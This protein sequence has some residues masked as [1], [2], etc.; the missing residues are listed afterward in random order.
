MIESTFT[1]KNSLKL[2]ALQNN[3]TQVTLLPL[4]K[5]VTAVSSA[6]LLG[7]GLYFRSSL[8]PAALTFIARLGLNYFS[9]PMPWEP[10][11]IG[12]SG[13]PL[14][15]DLERCFPEKKEQIVALASGGMSEEERAKCMI[16]V[17]IKGSI[18][19]FSDFIK[20]LR[21]E[22]NLNRYYQTIRAYLV[23]MGQLGFRL[24]SNRFINPTPDLKLD[25]YIRSE[26]AQ[27]QLSSLIRCAPAGQEPI[28]LE[29]TLIN[30]ATN[31][32]YPY[33]FICRFKNNDAKNT[34][35][36]Q[37]LANAMQLPVKMIVN[38][39]ETTLWPKSQ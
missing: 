6:I 36:C 29:K 2:Q 19:H 21:S 13:S 33:H 10:L 3:W 23:K 4:M 22:A 28:S 15:K 8:V 9:E 27:E 37:E 11:W 39:V 32:T 14:I 5:R 24:D 16:S 31:K 18:L 1:L 20:P 34:N 25:N 7:L 17:N 38:A 26:I 12:K 35:E 30:L